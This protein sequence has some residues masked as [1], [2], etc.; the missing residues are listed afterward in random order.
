[1]V[2]DLVGWRESGDKESQTRC[3]R[4]VKDQTAT[5]ILEAF[6]VCF[7]FPLNER[8]RKLCDKQRLI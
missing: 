8:K 4:Y 5:C 2:C 6:V 7:G 1:M 3:Q